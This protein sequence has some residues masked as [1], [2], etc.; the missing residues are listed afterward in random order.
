MATATAQ[1]P[2][3]T[4]NATA[5]RTRKVDV[6]ILDETE[7]AALCAL[8]LYELRG[9]SVTGNLPAGVWRDGDDY[10]VSAKHAQRMRALASGISSGVVFEREMRAENK[11]AEAADAPIREAIAQAEARERARQ[12]AARAERKRISDAYLA[13]ERADKDATS[14]DAVKSGKPRYNAVGDR[15]V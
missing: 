14:V 2:N 10:L 11:R 13:R 9:R 5:S 4:D 8:P 3:I 15:I 6:E 7:A 1:A 12:D